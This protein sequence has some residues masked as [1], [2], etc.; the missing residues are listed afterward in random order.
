[1]IVP[2][3]ALGLQWLL[4]DY[5]SPF[6]WFLFFPAIFFSARLGGFK[7]G[8][9]STVISAALVVFFFVPP[10]L[11]WEV[12]NPYNL[13]S[14]V[15]FLIMGYLFSD[16]QERFRVANRR[17]EAALAETRA[18]HEQ[19]TQLYQK[20]LELDELKTQFFANV[21]HE[22][23]T[24]LALILGP[25]KKCL[26]VPE[27]SPEMRHDLEVVERNARFLY[28]HVTDLLDVSK[29][30]SGHTALQYAQVDLAQLARITASQFDGI[31]IERGIVFTLEIPERLVAQVD[32]EKCQRILLN[33]LSNAFKFTPEGG[34][35]LL[36]LK[37]DLTCALFELADSGPGIPEDKREVIFERFRQLEGAT[38]RKHGGTGLGLSIVQEFVRLHQGGIRLSQAPTGGAL[39]AV[40]LPLM[41]PAGVALSAEPVEPEADLGR[42]L[43]D[44]LYL[45]RVPVSA[46]DLAGDE[47]A[48]VLVVEDNP[49]MNEF[50]T[51]SLKQR[52]R[53]ASAADG[54]TGLEKAIAL[55]PD[56]ILADVM[57]P[58]LS[59]DQMVLAIR[60]Q[61]SLKD[62]PIVMLTAKAD[63]KLR[64]DL[65]QGGAQDY[66]NK[67]FSVD[68]LLARVENL[69]SER[70]RATEKIRAS[71]LQYRNLF[72]NMVEGL[73]YCQVIF[74][75]GQAVD[76]IYLS[77]NPAFETLT[78]LKNAVGKR[79]SELVPGI[80]EFDPELF[81]IYARVA[82]LGKS[83]KFEMYLEALKM[84][85][86]IAVYCPEK[87]YFVAVFDVI[88][89]RKQ[90]EEALRASE[91]KY[92]F[93]VENITDVVWQISPDLHFI[94][95]SPTD[96]RQRGYKTEEVLGRSIFDFMTGESKRE[97]LD[98]AS[99]RQAL[100]QKGER[101]SAAVYEIEQTRKD[102]S[103]I[104]TE[105]TSNPV[106]DASGKLVYFQGVTRD[107]TQRKQAEAR[108]LESETKLQT[109]LANSRD[110]I[111]VSHLGV[112]VFANPAYAAMFGYENAAELIGT[113]ILGL[114]APESREMVLKNV[115]DRAR[116]LPAPSDYEVFALRKDESTFIMEV[117]VSTYLLDGKQYT[118]AIL[119][120]ISERKR[121]DEQ[122]RK[123]LAE[124]EI[125]L[126]ELYHRTKNN[127]NVII[128]LLELQADDFDDERLQKAFLDAQHRIH[129]MAL[130]HQ[131][132]YEASDLSRLNLKEYIT[133]LLQD[134][135]T[136]FHISTARIAVVLK[137]EDLFILID[138]A[139]PCGLILTELISNI[140]KYA[141]P[142]KRNG[143]IRIQ[144][145]RNESDEIDIC[146]SDNGVG[147][148]PGF[149]FRRDGHL[150]IQNIFLLG[151]GQLKGRVIFETEQGLTCHLRF[152]DVYYRP[153][154]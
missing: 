59:G 112:H 77:V 153:R 128:A 53:V 46:D 85:F 3:V 103:L 99:A 74:E 94:Y 76:W 52:Y 126:R 88:T 2:F 34:K 90:A 152:C 107:V 89:E 30:D 38:T 82:T 120:D 98:R 95:T 113:P 9:F 71:E 23:R 129:S 130:A 116:G 109:I 125:L 70:R 117:W 22:L 26:R 139:I 72:E 122:I 40:W 63:E 4:W 106:Y 47:A 51:A 134:L 61:A 147:V 55:A 37:T 17:T 10:E 118:L 108:L 132:L 60:Q 7:G 137:M 42:Q 28:R 145:H 91:E 144:L 50:I 100:T 124:K 141:F 58:N 24:P 110:A 67:P 13:F 45:E 20:T 78:G 92:R 115:Q 73:A 101:L 29:L 114:I 75:E 150:G 41:A 140:F 15:M 12:K 25:V 54:Q 138:A 66:I 119:R 65:L 56:L 143:E 35:I 27:L 16:I 5:I 21:S 102:G 136:S 44:E 104:W 48:L 142:D 31:A 62:V 127:M 49:D 11:S 111:G 43:I 146:V 80:R 154:V 151:E 96:E 121:T 105:I 39:F 149:D 64:V 68:E 32:P 1:M 131:K 86:S 123:S 33:L 148:P 8:L 93:L 79:V 97:I 81:N 135:I 84:W 69:L 36:T 57:M 18:A 19:I 6:V 133:D 87:E 83:E 14:V